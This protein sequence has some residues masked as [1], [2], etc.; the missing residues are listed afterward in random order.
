M[1]SARA[2]PRPIPR[3]L[4]VSG[5][6]PDPI[7]PFKTPVI[8]SFIDLTAERFDHEVISINR[9]SP[10]IRT[11]LASL[12]G[13]PGAP[14][15]THAEP[16]AFGSALSYAA[17][18]R[19]IFHRTSLERLGENLARKIE[20][21]AN[22]PDLMMAHK[23]S[24][25]GIAVSTAAERLGLPYGLTIQGNT[26]CK[27]I[28]ARPD[29]RPLFRDIYRRARVVFAF[30]PTTRDAIQRLLGVRDG[31]IRLLPC[32]TDLDH[33][34]APTPGGD[35]FLSVF[36]LK[37]YRVKNLHGIVRALEMGNDADAPIQLSVIGGGSEKDWAD[38]AT[39]ANNCPGLT[40]SGAL[41]RHGVRQ[42]MN[43]AIALVQPSRRESFGLVFIEALFAGL[44]IIY[45]ANTAIDGYFNDAPFALRVDASSHRSIRSAMEHAMQQEA[46]M[47]AA[48]TDWQNS[49][50]ARTFTREHIASVFGDG[51]AASLGCHNPAAAI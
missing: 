13:N 43:R 28:A 10:P 14:I 34:V 46:E 15:I 33:P 38:C 47:K 29:L 31:G 48:L 18:G 42:R 17:P 16:F 36:H 30:T 40:F 8:R 11:M 3:I 45:P 27:I 51:L 20:T 37:N 19:G 39:I 9:V 44:P 12:G 1:T 35:T 2:T 6:F 21:A 5:D 41:D 22:R 26:D 4:H 23:L 50:A 7:E 24:I 25:E 32:P 49:S